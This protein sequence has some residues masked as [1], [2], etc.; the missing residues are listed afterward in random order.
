MRY[1]VGVDRLLVVAD[2]TAR[3]LAS[4]IDR[5]FLTSGPLS[6]LLA[7]PNM[8]L[9]FVVVCSKQTS[10]LELCEDAMTNC[11]PC[12]F[13]HYFT[14]SRAVGVDAPPFPRNI[15]HFKHRTGN[16]GRAR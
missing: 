14:P 8:V 13:S 4:Q 11:G 2:S 16:R 3:H 7:V 12:R 15:L 6:S 10:G 5:I 1:P 9:L